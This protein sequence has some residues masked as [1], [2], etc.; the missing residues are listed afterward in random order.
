ML[1]DALAVDQNADL[2]TDLGR[3]FGHRAGE[4]VRDQL[5]RSDSASPKPL[6]RFDGAGL[7]AVGI[8]VDL[9]GVLL[10]DPVE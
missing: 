7:K 8:A 3:E 9:D 5:I 4:L 10:G 1:N 2:S 6:E